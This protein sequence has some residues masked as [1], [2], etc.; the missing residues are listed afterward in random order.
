[1]L[2]DRLLEKSQFDWK[3]LSG[4]FSFSKLSFSANWDNKNEP[5]DDVL[6]QECL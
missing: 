2:L 4:K 3:A 1:M 6:G 5:Q